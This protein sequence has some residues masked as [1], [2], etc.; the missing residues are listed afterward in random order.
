MGNQNNLNRITAAT[1]KA[2]LG[3]R[4]AAIIGAVNALIADRLLAVATIVI[5]AAAAEK[6]K[7]TTT[8]YFSIGGVIYS[9]AATDNLVFSAAYTVNNAQTA[10]TFWGAFLIQI[11]KAG[12]VSTKAVAS[13]QAY[14]SE[15]LAINNLPAPDA[16]KVKLGYI[17][18]NSKTGARWTANTDDL[19]DTSDVTEA[20]FYDG[21]TGQPAALTTLD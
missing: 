13:D 17:T 9:K 18:V 11:D 4:L 12:A 16:S 1:K 2:G 5:S 8:S 3:D 15:A 6:F 14:T 19:T 20:N 7:T 10:G 21:A